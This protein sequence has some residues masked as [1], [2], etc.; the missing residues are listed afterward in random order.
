MYDNNA[1]FYPYE[2]QQYN[3]E[4]Q[5]AGE[6]GA[7]GRSN[8]RNSLG[9]FGDAVGPTAAEML[10]RRR[11]RNLRNKATQL[12]GSEL[13]NKMVQADQTNVQNGVDL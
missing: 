12:Y 11:Y 2:L 1:Q 13:A 5:A 6:L 9:N 4:Q 3:K 8:L 7:L 10:T